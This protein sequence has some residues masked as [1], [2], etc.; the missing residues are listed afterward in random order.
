[1]KSI[2]GAVLMLLA[3]SVS[4][5]LKAAQDIDS[6]NYW[7]EIC[8]REDSFNLMACGSFISG[9]WEGMMFQSSKD[10]KP[11]AACIP[12][13]VTFGQQREIWVKYMR[14]HPE[15]RHLRASLLYFAAMNN[16]FP[17][18]QK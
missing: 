7:Y 8:G 14:E 15:W 6:G 10:K 12:D 5:P 18:R 17:C 4:V 13:G 2:A 1:M 3:L 11:A 16:V 9:I